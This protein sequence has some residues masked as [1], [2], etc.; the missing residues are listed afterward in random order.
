MTLKDTEEKLYDP[1]SDLDKREYQ[2]GVFDI[3]NA[4]EAQGVFSDDKIQWN[5]PSS[6]LGKEKRNAIYAGAFVL[7]LI[8]FGV[9][10][11]FVI[12]KLKETAFS[13]KNVIISIEGP[14]AIGSAK[15]VKYIIKY[16]NKN[17][18][19]L[20][21]VELILNHTE[22]FYPD[23][24]A[25]L[26]KNN[27]R[28]SRLEIEDVGMFGSGE[29]EVTGKFYAAENYTVYLQ[30]TLKYKP[31]NFNSFFEA[32]SQLGVRIIN[33]PIALTINVPKEALDE[34]AIDYEINYKNTGASSLDGLSL[35]LEYSD[36]FIFQGATPMPVSGNNVWYLGNLSVG[37][38]NTI[39]IKGGV[40]GNQ[41]DVKLI[42]ATIY[43]NQSN[44]AEVIYGRA[45][46]VTKIVMP[47]LNIVHKIDGNNAANVNLGDVLRYKINYSNRGETGFKDIIVKLK[48]DSPIIDYEKIDLK[49]GAYSS[50]TKDI[51]WK[52]ADIEGLKKLDPGDAGMIEVF[53]PLK[54]K[55]DINNIEDKNFLIESVVT[56]DSSDVAF[57]SLGN[58]KNI[59]NTVIAKLNSRVIL[60]SK[61]FYKDSNIENSGPIP[62]KTGEETTYTVN[63]KVSNVSNDISDVKV[64]AFLPTW[65][66]WKNV[67]FPEGENISFNERTHEV[68][69]N[70][71]KLENGRGILNAPKEVKFKIGLT[72]ELN[73]IND[74]IDLVY[75]T[76]LTGKDDFTLEGIEKKV[77]TRNNNLEEFTNN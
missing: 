3:E 31:S 59:S 49:T 24:S 32:T 68:N 73:Q 67:I 4:Q 18:V 51:T 10:I 48:I 61:V 30:P 60:E 33:S 7:G 75:E 1:Q 56:I 6:W 26:K 44:S 55:I 28:S 41:Y 77:G 45:E 43:K 25:K 19:S 35:R 74:S 38:N 47:P 15:D 39:K 20:K 23:E 58:S 9:G 27:D 12:N 57:R 66:V 17:R 34:S 53:I 13:E 21:N 16:K 40:D 11:F 22:N 37:A 65:I 63:W 69:W 70:I 54:D 50:I 64:S 29:I 36:G 5:K 62:Q 2:K 46:G 42:K 14:T 71:G 52:A 76:K 8:I 72:P